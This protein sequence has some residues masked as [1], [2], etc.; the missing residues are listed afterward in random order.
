MTVRRVLAAIT[1]LA[2]IAIGRPV[3]A[4]TITYDFWLKA[5]NGYPV[6]DLVL[7]AA[8]ASQDD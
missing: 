6:T 2:A 8:N 3:S 5:P 7:Y 4:A 1:V